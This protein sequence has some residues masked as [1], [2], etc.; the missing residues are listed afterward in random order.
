MSDFIANNGRPFTRQLFWEEWVDLPIDQRVIEP[1]YSL[2]RDKPGLI[3]F[4]KAY[5]EARD[6]T[7][8]AVSQE[9]LY[10]YSHWQTLLRCKWFLAAKEVWDR[11]LDAAI[12]SEGM[13]KIRQLLADGLPAQ[14]LA[15]AKYLANREYRKDKSATKGRPSNDQIAKE[16]ARQAEFDRELADDAK[17]IRLVKG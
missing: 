9:L 11:E 13:A 17:R 2:Y 4:G 10:D 6:P 15:A 12:A 8:Y 1:K 14:Q 16:A 7:G 3:N 5:V